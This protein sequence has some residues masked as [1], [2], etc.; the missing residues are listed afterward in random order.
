MAG[1]V[2]A[3]FPFNQA[4][5]RKRNSNQMTDEKCSQLNNSLQLERMQTDLFLSQLIRT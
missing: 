5:Q 4:Q 3:V 1:T 2:M